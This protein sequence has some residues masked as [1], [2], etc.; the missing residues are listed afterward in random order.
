MEWFSS[1]LYH[2]A[3]LFPRLIHITE[4]IRGV[5]LKS[6][7]HKKLEPGY[8]IY[9]PLFTELRTCCITRQELDLPEQIL[10]TLDGRT[11]VA[12]ASIVYRIHGVIKALIGTQNYETTVIEVAQRAVKYMV[13]SHVADYVT[14]HNE[15]FDK[16]LIKK[17][18]KDVVHYGLKIDDAFLTSC[19]IT[20]PFHI[21][22]ITFPQAIQ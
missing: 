9:W 12:S 7:T 10:T 2:M 8:S 6:G 1:L 5:K 17:I 20:T 16:E 21:T 15:E 22:G 11:V 14:T 13:S 18:Q 4:D 3:N 19:A